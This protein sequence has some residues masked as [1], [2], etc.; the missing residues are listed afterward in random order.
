MTD[1]NNNSSGLPSHWKSR[2]QDQA[3]AYNEMKKYRSEKRRRKSMDRI[4]NVHMTEA[5]T[6]NSGNLPS[7][8]IKQP[9]AQ[10][11]PADHTVPRLRL[12]DLRPG[13]VRVAILTVIF[14]VFGM[15]LF[16][17]EPG[18]LQTEPTAQLPYGT[19]IA[20]RVA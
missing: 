14:L 15:M 5:P 18:N 6:A 4:A 3:D 8:K 7:F 13:V 2:L 1:V 10:Q 16:A 11:L 20:F 12:S 17:A 19:W 9:I